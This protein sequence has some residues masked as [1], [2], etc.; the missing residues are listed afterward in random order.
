MG[1]IL[2]FLTLNFLRKKIKKRTTLG[3]HFISETN[4]LNITCLTSEFEKRSGVARLLWS[5]SNI[6]KSVCL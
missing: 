5:F 4:T 1:F 2:V 3:L 6:S